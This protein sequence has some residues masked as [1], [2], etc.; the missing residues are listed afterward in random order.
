[1]NGLYFYKLV[2][3]YQEDITKDC[4]LT[5]NEIDSNFLTLKNNEISNAYV[6]NEEKQIHIVKNDGEEFVLNL[7]EINKNASF[8]VDYDSVDGVIEITYD[9]ETYKIKDLITKDNLSKEILTKVFTD[10]TLSGIGTAAAP[11][12]IASIQK[13]GSYKAAIKLVDTTLNE[14]LPNKGMAKGDR[15]VTLEEV[16]DFGLLYNFAAVKQINKMLENTG[17]RVATK[18]DWDNMLNAIEPCEHRD[19][20]STLNNRVLGH[21]AGSLLKATYGWRHNHK[22]ECP[23]KPNHGHPKHEDFDP[24]A[25]EETCVKEKY[26]QHPEKKPYSSEGKD[27]YGMGI[28]PGGYAYY[29]RPMQYNQFGFQG[30]YWTS[31]MLYDTDVYTK[32]FEANESGVLQ[33]GE[34]PSAFLSIRLVKDYDGTNDKGIENILGDNYHTVLMPT[35]NNPNG[36]AIWTA[37][38]LRVRDAHLEAAI[39]NAG[40]GVERVKT[41]F[42]NEWN[43]FG[44]DRLQMEEGDTIVILN[45]DKWNESYRIV[46]GKLINVTSYIAANIRHE[47]KDNLDAI[48][49]RIHEAEHLINDNHKNIEKIN[50]KISDIEVVNTIQSDQIKHVEEEVKNLKHHHIHDIKEILEKIEENASSTQE[51][52]DELTKKDEELEAKDAEI[53]ESLTEEAKAREEADNALSEAIEAEAARAKEVEETLQDKID[54]ETE[55]REKADEVLQDAIVAVED[56]VED[57]EKHRFTAESNYDEKEGKITLVAEDPENNIEITLGFDFGTL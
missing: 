45:S 21:V 29:S 33:L 55:E 3:P 8:N 43:G 47:L 38:N 52:L 17:W 1:M 12:S 50:E 53:E 4:K 31:D 56:R 19:H 7:S 37:Q 27:A 22:P 54:T 44:W 15:Y 2:S 6:N 30:A 42:I 34:R 23:E 14:R 20:A 40:L 24:C 39:P 9:G 13:T 46:E 41:Y 10:F 36:Y 57:L 5:I 32:V 51:K 35:L 49:C 16:S 26:P 48:R 11:L 18:A 28:L 25:V